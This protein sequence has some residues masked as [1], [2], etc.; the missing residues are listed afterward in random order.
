MKKFILILSFFT[1]LN[2]FVEGQQTVFDETQVLYYSEMAGGVILHTSGLG[3]NF[4]YAKNI[5][6][7]R[8]QVY[9][10][11]LV[12]MK[13][14]REIKTL[15]DVNNI[16]GYF[17]G[18]QNSLT[19]LRT[20][21]GKQNTFIPKQNLK[22]VAISSDFNYGISHGFAKPVYL[23]IGYSDDRPNLIFDEIRDE[24]YDPQRHFPDNILGR[25]SIF[26]GLDEIKYYPGL[27]LKYGLNFEYS[28]D[29]DFIKAIE[30]G[31][32]IDAFYKEIPI[33]AFNANQQVFYSFYFNFIY[34]KRKTAGELRQK[35]QKKPKLKPESEEPYP[36]NN[37]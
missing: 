11:E 1:L 34:G 23:A 35:K 27:Y 14:E 25:A 15:S 29:S 9:E 21:F 7:F 5:T 13:H 16:R 10:A 17:Y 12:G 36:S 24:K 20:S 37:Q 8:R 32:T 28:H 2:K 3:I 26:K 22:G 33:M 6:A 4:L 18:K 31:A 30:V 19:I